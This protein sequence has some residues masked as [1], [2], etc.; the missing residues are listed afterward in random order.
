MIISV[1]AQDV[2]N[3]PKYISFGGKQEVSPSDFVQASVGVVDGKLVLYPKFMF[4]AGM[5]LPENAQPL[6]T[7]IGKTSFKYARAVGQ[8]G[9]GFRFSTYLK[10]YNQN[11]LDINAIAWDQTAKIVEKYAPENQI[12]L[13]GK[14]KFNTYTN[15][16]KVEQFQ[17]GMSVIDFSFVGKESGTANQNTSS[18]AKA[19]FVDDSELAF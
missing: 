18:V 17:I 13:S 7:I 1:L 2:L 16:E 15:K 14:I 4:D 9:I 11:Y 8:E 19:E 3:F 6:S 12:V 10:G 5:D